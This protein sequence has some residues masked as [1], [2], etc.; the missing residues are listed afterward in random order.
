MNKFQAERYVPVVLTKQGERTALSNLPGHVTARLT[1]L[2]VVPPIEWD[3]EN[4]APKKTQAEHLTQLPQQ[5]AQC[6]GTAPAFIDLTFL[7]DEVVGG[8]VHPLEWVTNQTRAMGLTLTPVVSFD[9]TDAYLDAAAAVIQRDHAG[10]C[11][12][13]PIDEWPTAKGVSLLDGFLSQLGVS[14]AEAHLVLDLAEDVGTAA[15]TA[16]T[17]ELRGLPYRDDWRS[18]TVTGTAMPS[19]MPAGPGLHTITRQEWA[20]YEHLANL[21]TPLERMPGFGDYGVGGV[22]PSA[23]VDPKFMNI[24]ATLRYT[25]HDRWLIAKGGLWKGNG[26]K[27]IGAAAV[28]PAARL[29][30]DHTEYLG[31]DHCQFEVWMQPVA[32]G[33]GGGSAVVWRRYGTQ[34]HFTVVTDQLASVHGL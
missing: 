13:L 34:H 2:F 19:S 4:E 20:I 3:Y 16:V 30:Q 11:L 5:L 8:G 31:A 22:S 7:D 9:R 21:S 25:V 26:G 15:R 10:V 29:L 32:A 33:T 18:V 12:R 1:P 24:S 17:A 28:P 27:G 6:W 14:A 23:D